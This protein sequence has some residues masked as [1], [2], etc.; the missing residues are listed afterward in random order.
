MSLQPG[1]LLVLHAAL[2]AAAA[3][4]LAGML[5][6]M[7]ARLAGRRGAPVIQPFRD[8]RRWAR[9]QPQLPEGASAA[10]A[11]APLVSLAALA[12]AALLVPSFA[13]GLASAPA[14]DLIVLAGLLALS[15]AAMAAA[16]LASGRAIGGLAA[17]RAMSLAVLTEPALLLVVFTVAVMAGSTNLDVVAGVLRDGG[18]GV[19]IWVALAMAAA[20]IVALAEAGRFAW[21]GGLLAAGRDT[22]GLAFSGWHLAVVAYG[23]WLR[24]LV[25]LSLLLAVF[26]PAGIAPAGAGLAACAV[27]VLAWAAKLTAMTAGLALVQAAQPMLRWS[28]MPAL[29]GVALLLGLLAAL[30]LF[31]GQSSA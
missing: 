9:K 29:L 27:G 13:L 12:S 11:A 22:G 25:W 6:A 21:G 24:L 26:A 28:R 7:Q 19:R 18:S 16:G 23:G 15:R 20:A 8:L 31:A 3:P 1:V 5:A 4:A 2:M 14:A 30:F 17:G 10:L